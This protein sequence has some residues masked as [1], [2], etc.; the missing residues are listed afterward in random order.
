[1]LADQ[2]ITCI[3][4]RRNH[5][6]RVPYSKRLYKMRHNIENLLAKLKDWRPPLQLVITAVPISFSLP[7]LWPLSSSSRY[8]A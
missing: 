7:T 5:N 4:P 3:P 1:M 2:G 8:E 6:R